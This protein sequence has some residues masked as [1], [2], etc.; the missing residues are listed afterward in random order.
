MKHKQADTQVTLYLQG[1]TPKVDSLASEEIRRLQEQNNTLRA[2]VAQ[3]RKDMEGLIHA[4]STPQAQP[5]TSTPKGH[6]PEAPAATSTTLTAEPQIATEP[7]PQS[8]DSPAGVDSTVLHQQNFFSYLKGFIKPLSL[9][10]LL[11]IM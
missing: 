8:K 7:P 5:Q 4:V 6:H 3:M 10:T 11:A 1:L 2:V 9:M